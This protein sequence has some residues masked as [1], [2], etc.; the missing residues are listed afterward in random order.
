L[1]VIEDACQAHGAEYKGKRAGSFGDAA[2]FSFYPGKN[3]GAYG[4]GGAVVTS[5][6]DIEEKVRLL[7]DYGQKQKYHHIIKG[8]NNRLD[9]IQA[10]VLSVKLKHLEE[11]NEKRR[12]NARVYDKMLP[13]DIPRPVESCGSKHVYHL[14][15]VRVKERDRVIEDLRKKGI[16]A[17]IHYPI[18][19][20]LQE[21]YSDLGYKEGSFP[22]TEK[23]ANEVLSLPMFPELSEKEIEFVSDALR[24]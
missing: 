22:V 19:I 23:A 13:D 9:A 4:D 15:V 3:L 10:A 1:K 11:W 7:R 18:P 2:A 17:G 12:K 6:D 16:F 24:P 21:A 8:H 20:H 5:N 14:Y